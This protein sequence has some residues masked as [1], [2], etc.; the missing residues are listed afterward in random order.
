[1]DGRFKRALGNLLLDSVVGVAFCSGVGIVFVIR[2]RVVGSLNVCIFLGYGLFA[3][4]SP[5]ET[6]LI[7]ELFL[8]GFVS[9]CERPITEQCT[10]ATVADTTPAG[11]CLVV[12]PIVQ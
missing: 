8:K 4:I 5:C 9:I 7:F 3:T 12:R 10:L 2:V 6:G 1:L 11:P